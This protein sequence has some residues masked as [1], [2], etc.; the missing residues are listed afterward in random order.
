M[1]KLGFYLFLAVATLPLVAQQ[2]PAPEKK[3]FLYLL[4][5]VPEYHDPKAWGEKESDMMG[6]HFQHLQTLLADGVLI[7]AGKTEEP[8]EITFGIVIFEAADEQAARDLMN[9]DP[10]VKAKMV[11]AEL[12]PY[13]VALRRE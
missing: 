9:S 7:L 10:L 5:L 6:L 4:R 12:H 1:A 13:Q 3:Q 8:N 2:V 11:T